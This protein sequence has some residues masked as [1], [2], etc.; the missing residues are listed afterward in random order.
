MGT[1][2][3]GTKAEVRALDTFIKLMRCSNSVQAPLDRRLD[4]EGLTS[5][6]FGVLETLL[7]LGPRCQR[8]L[9]EKLLT[10]GGNIT[11]VV[12]NLERRNL[13]QRVRSAEDRRFVSVHLTDEGRALIEKVFP[14]HAARI[15]ESMSVLTPAEQEE[16]ARLCKKLGLGQQ[17]LGG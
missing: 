15:T 13:V 11:T 2:Y 3:K 7:H 16:L 12:D 9:G 4:E 14:R 17:A 1:H 6:Q 10:S 5:T 8:E